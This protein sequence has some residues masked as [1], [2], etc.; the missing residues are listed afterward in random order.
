MHDSVPAHNILGRSAVRC[1]TKPEKNSWII[2][3]FTPKI[4]KPTHCSMR[5]YSTCDTEPLRTWTFEGSC[6]G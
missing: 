3:D 1:V 2:I 5:H 6:D 4:I